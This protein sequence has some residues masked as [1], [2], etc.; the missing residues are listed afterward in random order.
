MRVYDEKSFVSFD[1]LW[2]AGKLYK[3]EPVET[4]VWYMY[5]PF[6]VFGKMIK[7]GNG[8]ENLTFRRNISSFNRL[9]TTNLRN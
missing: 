3:D 6:L 1:R 9:P 5:K 4:T 2:K 8:M 7:A